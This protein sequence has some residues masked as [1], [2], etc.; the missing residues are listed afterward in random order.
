MSNARRSVTAAGLFAVALSTPSMLPE[1]A[2]AA[3]PYVLAVED[4]SAKVGQSGV[5]VARL[6]IGE[7]Y[8]LLSAYNNRLTRLSSFDEGVDFEGE[9]VRPRLEGGD[10]VF[11]IGFVPTKPGAHPINGVFR[12][13]YVENGETMK[14]V[15]VPL[16]AKIVG[17]E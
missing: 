15:S 2:R 14:M 11:D 10:L 6:R 9:V 17:T 12:I 13:G 8:R 5:M 16:M 1:T 3:E 7:G 4:A